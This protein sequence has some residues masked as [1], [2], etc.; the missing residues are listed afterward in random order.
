MPFVKCRNISKIMYYV[1]VQKP[2]FKFCMKNV[3]VKNLFD[4]VLLKKG[5]C[6]QR[7][8]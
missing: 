2:M 6:D 3:S 7:L 1:Y 5:W 4:A 8:Q